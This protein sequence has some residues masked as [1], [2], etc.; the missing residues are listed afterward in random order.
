MA[1]RG[2]CIRGAPILRRAPFRGGG[3]NTRFPIRRGGALLDRSATAHN[4][5]YGDVANCLVVGPR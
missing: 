1:D 4:A 5:T 2:N 3:V